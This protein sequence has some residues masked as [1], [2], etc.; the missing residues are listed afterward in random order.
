MLQNP[1][2]VGGAI[3]VSNFASGNCLCRRM[4]SFRFVTRTAALRGRPC[5]NCERAVIVRSTPLFDQCAAAGGARG[6]LGRARP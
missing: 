4:R 1:E 3:L 2:P 6:I 5:A